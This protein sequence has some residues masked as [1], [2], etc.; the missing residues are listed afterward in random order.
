M[1]ERPSEALGRWPANLLLTHGEG[2][3][4]E[5]TR[6]ASRNIVLRGGGDPDAVSCYGDGLHGNSTTGV[7][8]TV[9]AWDCAPDCPVGELDRQSGTLT[10]GAFDGVRNGTE[11]RST[12]GTFLGN[13]GAPRHANS[14]GASRFYP[15]FRYVPKAP[16]AMRE[17]GL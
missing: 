4:Q 7:T 10:S 1:A 5:G 9:T 3:R 12:C 8:E 14:G 15:T 2:C 11:T 6:A 17:A 13:Q 16:R